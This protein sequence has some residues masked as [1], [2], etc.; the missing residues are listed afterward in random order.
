MNT[1]H[2]LQAR[3][4]H[5]RRADHEQ[6]PAWNPSHLEMKA[7]PTAWHLPAWLPIAAA[8]CLLLSFLWLRD[9]AP[10]TDLSAAMPELFATEGEPLFANLSSHTPSD[11]FLPLHLTIQ[12]P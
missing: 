7:S 4:A 6:A 1:D 11:F 2:E 8:A 9:D 10:A 5:L 3:F 12:L